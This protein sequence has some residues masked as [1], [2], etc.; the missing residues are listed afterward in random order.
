MS[1]ARFGG[2]SEN[3]GTIDFYLRIRSVLKSDQVVLDLGA[4]RAQWYE[5]DVVET[6]RN[7]RYIRPL[8][9]KMIAVDVDE[10]V[11]AN[12]S[13]TENLTYDG[14]TIP[15]ED[16]SVDVVVADYVLEHVEDPHSFQTEIARVLK[17]RGYFF[18]RTPHKYHYVSIFA[19]IFE[20]KHHKSL[21]SR[22]Q[23]NRKAE[24]V[25]PTA[26]KLNTLADVSKS[27]EN[28]KNQSFIFRSPPAYYFGSEA[29]LKVLNL[30]HRLLPALVIGNLFIIMRRP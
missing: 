25:F 11:M 28:W 5:D 4:G 18:A 27:F 29:L 26:Y 17:P 8:V 23:P 20:N 1:N 30:A 6:R 7:I 14:I 21:L 22:I 10:A 24:D 12:R 2:F 15:L 9:H 16:N 13:S 3:D 19:R